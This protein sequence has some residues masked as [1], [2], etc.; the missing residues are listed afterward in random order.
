MIEKEPGNPKIHRLRFIHLL[1][2]DYNLI[3]SIKW[4]ES[5]HHIED[6]KQFNANQYG[7]QPGNCY[8]EPIVIQELQNKIDWMIQKTQIKIAM[9]AAAC[10]DRM[11]P[12]L[13]NLIRQRFGMHADV[14]IVQ[15]KTLQ[16]AKYHIHTKLGIS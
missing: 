3:L 11:I 6:H 15:G 1:E 5:V 7:S 10:Y 16:E 14:C 9:D 13:C 8:V 2:F 4:R 12:G